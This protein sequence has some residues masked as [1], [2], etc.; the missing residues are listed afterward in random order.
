MPPAE[1]TTWIDSLRRLQGIPFRYL[2]PDERVLPVE[3]IRFFSVDPQ[4]VDT[5]LDGAL[6]TVR[7]PTEY[8]QHC[9]DAERVLLHSGPYCITGFLLRSAAVAGWPGLEVTGRGAVGPLERYRSAQLSPAILL[10]LFRGEVASVTIRQKP[11]T[12]H[13]SL[14]DHKQDADIWQDKTQRVLKPAALGTGSGSRFAQTLLHRLQT[15]QVSVTG[16]PG[17]DPALSALPWP[18]ASGVTML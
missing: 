8:Q 15:L 13:L 4:W 12:L 3:S 2:V 6:S 18:P 9:Q 7:A 5:L 16:M 17:G 11:D 10:Y 1:L 14:E